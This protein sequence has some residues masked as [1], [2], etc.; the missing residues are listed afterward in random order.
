MHAGVMLSWCGILSSC[1]SRILVAGRDPH[2]P[3][4]GKYGNYRLKVHN[5]K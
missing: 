4:T 1:D 2:T 5:E 3:K